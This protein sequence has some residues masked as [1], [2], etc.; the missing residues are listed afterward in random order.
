M[1]SLTSK[2]WPPLKRI[3][4]LSPSLVRALAK[5]LRGADSEVPALESD[6]ELE[7]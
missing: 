6:P 1:E 4:T 5:V 3:S 2:V 7:T